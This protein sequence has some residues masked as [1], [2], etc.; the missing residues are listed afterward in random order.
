M[1]ARL[2]CKWEYNLGA[3]CTRVHCAWLCTVCTVYNG[4]AP[5]ATCGTRALPP[6]SHFPSNPTSPFAHFPKSLRMH[7]GR[8]PNE[9]PPF[10]KRHPNFSQ[11]HSLLLKKSFARQKDGTKCE[12]ISLFLTLRQ[13]TPCIN[14]TYITS[15]PPT[16]LVL[17]CRSIS[18]LS[19]KSVLQ[20]DTCS[21]LVQR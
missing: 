6:N 10:V 11:F 3:A 7:R 12:E 5:F 16:S 1:Q 13:E 4:I 2:V 9:E 18:P 15:S 14:I 19:S 20:F 8:L 21:I 17:S